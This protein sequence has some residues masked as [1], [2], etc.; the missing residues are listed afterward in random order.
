MKNGELFKGYALNQVWPRQ[1]KLE[2]LY[3]WKFD[4]P[5][6][7]EPLGEV[8]QIGSF[9]L[10]RRDSNLGVWRMLSKYWAMR[11]VG[12]PALS[13]IRRPEWAW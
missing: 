7:T 11:A 13:Q 9:R 6:F 3:F 8:I 4:E 10:R 1:K 2:P 5:K 12:V